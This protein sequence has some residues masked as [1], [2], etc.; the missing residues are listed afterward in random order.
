MSY[1]PRVH[2]EQEEGEVVGEMGLMGGSRF[3]RTWKTPDFREQTQEKE[4]E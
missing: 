4:E 3:T 2:M 1:G